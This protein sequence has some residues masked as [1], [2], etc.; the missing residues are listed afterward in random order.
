M[1]PAPTPTSRPLAPSSAARPGASP[2]GVQLPLAPSP[3]GPG[4]EVAAVAV[5]GYN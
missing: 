4:E 3:A 2:A 5:L 1:H